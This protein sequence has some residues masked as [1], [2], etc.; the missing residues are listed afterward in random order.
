ME[1]Q[2]LWDSE[3]CVDFGPVMQFLASYL[4]SLDMFPHL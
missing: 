3:E 2:A 4:M 1:R